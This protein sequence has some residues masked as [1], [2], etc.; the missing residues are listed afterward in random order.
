MPSE[1]QSEKE[2]EKKKKEDKKEES[3]ITRSE[4]ESGS[5]TSFEESSRVEDKKE[6]P[7]KPTE[8]TPQ[9][10]VGGTEPSKTKE[11][12]DEGEE[13]TSEEKTLLLLLD[14]VQKNKYDVSVTGFQIKE[15][16]ESIY[17]EVNVDEIYYKLKEKG[18]VDKKKDNEEFRLTVEGQRQAE[19]N[20]ESAE[21][22]LQRIASQK[23][24][25]IEENETLRRLLWL[26]YTTDR[27]EFRKYLP[28]MKTK[29][30]EEDEILVC[31][32]NDDKFIQRPE[33]EKKLRELK[34]RETEN[35]QKKLEELAEDS[36][37][38]K[39]LAMLR[40]EKVLKEL[41]IKAQN[42]TLG[43]FRKLL[44]FYLDDVKKSKVLSDMLLLGLTESENLFKVDIDS[45]LENKI[46]EIESWLQFDK[47]GILQESKRNWNLLLTL[48]KAVESPTVDAWEAEKLVEYN[49]VVP[50]KD[51]YIVRDEA[52]SVWDTVYKDIEKRLAEKMKGIENAAQLPFFDL[53]EA[54]NLDEKIIVTL[55]AVDGSSRKYYFPAFVR[56][57]LET[58]ERS[59]NL[60]EDKIV[61]VVSPKELGFDIID[62]SKIITRGSHPLEE[63][64][65]NKEY[66]AIGEVGGLQELKESFSECRW[67]S[68]DDD[69]IVKK[70]KEARERR[71][72]PKISFQ[73]AL[74]EI[75]EKDPVHQEALYLLAHKITGSTAISNGYF[76]ENLMWR[77]L[78]SNLRV[79]YPELSESQFEEIKKEIKYIM[80]EKAENNLLELNWPREAE[81]TYNN[82]K[83][84]LNEQ[85]LQ[86]IKNLDDKSKKALLVFLE[87]QPEHAGYLKG[88]YG[89]YLDKFN[90]LYQLYFSEKPEI[91]LPDL[92]LKVGLVVEGTWITAK[93][94]DNG[95][96]YEF[97][98]GLDEVKDR[99]LDQIDVRVEADT[100]SFKEKFKDSVAELAGVEF[101]LRN[102]GMADRGEMREAL[103]NISQKAWMEFK[104]YPQII[105]PKNNEKIALNPKVSEEIEKWLI[106]R[107][108]ELLG[109]KKDLL[110]V[111]ESLDIVDYKLDFQEDTGIYKGF[112]M[113]PDRDQIN[114]I[115]SPW[116]LPT[117]SALLGQKN[118]IIATKKYNKDVFNH[119][120]EME[121]KKTLFVGFEGGKF[122]VFSNLQ[123]QKFV[124][125]IIDGMKKNYKLK[126]KNIEVSDEEGPVVEYEEE[127][128]VEASPSGGEEPSTLF[129]KIFSTEG[130]HFPAG[131]AEDRSVV[132]ILH[133]TEDDNFGLTVQT[134]CREL[135]HEFKGG[136]PS[137]RIHSR[138]EEIEKELEAEGNIQLVDE[139]NERFFKGSLS[140]VRTIDTVK[141][142]EVKRRLQELYSQGLGFIIFQVPSSIAGKFREKLE[143]EVS[144]HKPD[145]IELIPQIHGTKLL[146]EEGVIDIPVVKQKIANE[147]WGRV[148]DEDAVTRLKDFDELFGEAEKLFK[149]KLNKYSNQLIRSEGKERSPDMLVKESPKVADDPVN[150]ESPLHYNLKVFVVKSLA[151]TEKYSLESIDTEE[152]T[153]TAHDS[154]KRVIP[155]VQA[156]NRVFEIE[157][158][159]SSGKPLTNIRRTIEKYK[160]HEPKPE[161][162]IVLTNL[163]A[164]LWYK[165]LK[166]FQKEVREDWELNLR[167]KIP[168]LKEK[169]LLN[170]DNIRETINKALQ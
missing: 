106:E 84:G 8:Q 166:R 42:R 61:L 138:R 33:I 36:D 40:P 148:L 140:N 13:V 32:F 60:L 27:F 58:L 87:F 118:L 52:K 29:L 141:W 135:Y 115:I 102:N 164:F 93:G 161:V 79:R 104:E 158:L 67:V 17:P 133:D 22:V 50:S 25:H 24:E 10:E 94:N 152:D 81:E 147:I 156:G 83:D 78:K 99:V 19:R 108:K 80:E 65:K 160:D 71:E 125:S 116:Y 47:D 130:K 64:D 41:G 146:T 97:Y 57:C 122:E 20:Q 149:D 107:K 3:I 5:Q 134:I 43:N 103:L 131:L 77:D 14:L 163:D 56:G 82:L 34:K 69:L 1:K 31:L 155:D 55:H 109:E 72:I 113:T 162:N 92:L 26:A 35:I 167:L 111:L 143:D 168:S 110:P 157:T 132:I 48:R 105:P 137:P 145:I 66:N 153:P 44:S 98:I 54:E 76:P 89:D 62:K 117:Y 18:F 68:M 150:N 101:L 37:F 95:T 4:K 28:E 139:T 59:Q 136:L 100:E 128:E 120:R 9:T 114:I 73:E 46:K 165:E 86:R 16:F 142:D 169:R 129:D 112:V 151:E 96:D 74:E 126:E 75:K 49:A 159:Y 90:T 45:I 38:L 119:F 2:K 53:D 144:P 123:K 124:D 30:G 15:F 154:E 91:S 85:I 121:F 23:I 21:E 127:A 170:I 39:A 11:E 6:K 51:G 70:A 7:S 88:E 12:E 63:P